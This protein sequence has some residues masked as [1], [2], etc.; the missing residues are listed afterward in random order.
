LGSE[1]KHGYREIMAKVVPSY[2]IIIVGHFCKRVAIYVSF[3]EQ[4]IGEEPRALK[5]FNDLQILFIRIS[6]HN[7]KKS[8]LSARSMKMIFS[9]C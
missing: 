4:Y 3:S 9:G 8:S 2:G 7:F 1:G 6:L 5:I